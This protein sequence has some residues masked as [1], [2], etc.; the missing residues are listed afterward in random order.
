MFIIQNFHWI[1]PKNI[2]NFKT[3]E[4]SEC[5][6]FD[7]LALSAPLHLIDFCLDMKWIHTVDTLLF[8]IGYDQV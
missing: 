7:V 3:L 8:L 2:N 6:G 5:V 4:M 1:Q